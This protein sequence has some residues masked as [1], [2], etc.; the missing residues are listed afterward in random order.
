MLVPNASINPGVGRAL[1]NE[2]VAQLLDAG[3]AKKVQHLKG[4]LNS[5]FREGYGGEGAIVNNVTIF[6]NFCVPRQQSV[7]I[8]SC[9]L[10]KEK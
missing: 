1:R 4:G 10:N 5:W 9:K 2:G 8:P 7:L 3:A 6:P